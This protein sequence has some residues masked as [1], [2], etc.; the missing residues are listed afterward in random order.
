MLCRINYVEPTKILAF[1]KCKW[2]KYARRHTIMLL[3]DTELLNV[4]RRNVQRSFNRLRL[5]PNCGARNKGWMICVRHLLTFALEI[6][7][8]RLCGAWD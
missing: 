6:Y 1:S 8:N 4:N 7:L 3:D 5:T 2:Q